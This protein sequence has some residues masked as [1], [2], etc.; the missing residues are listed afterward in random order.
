MNINWEVVDRYKKINY[1]SPSK[2]IQVRNS[3]YDLSL[4]MATH[5]ASNVY[6]VTEVCEYLKAGSRFPTPDYETYVDYYKQRHDQ[7]IDP[8]QNMLEVKQ[9]SKKINC[10]KPR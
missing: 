8:S 2:P 10:I 7:V 5:R 9:I 4:V 1:V 3:E 6:I